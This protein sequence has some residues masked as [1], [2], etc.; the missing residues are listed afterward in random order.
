[1]VFVIEKSELGNH[2]TRT[3]VNDTCMLMASVTPGN[4][5]N[6]YQRDDENS[7]WIQSAAWSNDSSE[8]LVSGVCQLCLL[9]QQCAQQ[10]QCHDSD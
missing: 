1:M 10:A 8:D 3:A 7:A 5:V 9:L 4:S 6:I 2:A